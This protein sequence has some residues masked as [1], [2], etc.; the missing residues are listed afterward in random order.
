MRYRFRLTYAKNELM[1]YTSNL[2]VHKSWE[3]TIRRA[4]LPIA[5]SEGF[6][7]QPKIQL[8][9]PLPLGFLSENE[10]LDFELNENLPT[11]EILNLLK[12]KT[13]PGFEIFEIKEVLEKQPSLQVQT[14][15]SQYRIEFL[16]PQAFDLLQARCQNILNEI[17]IQRERRGKK[18]DLR[19]LIEMLNLSL[20]DQDPILTM[21]LSARAGATGRPEEVL[22]Q[23]NIPLNK[24]RITR[25]KT[26]LD[27]IL[28]N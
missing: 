15:A 1:R 5:Y 20:E 14:V 4:K 17:T 24:T 3:R 9:C 12:G 13:P 28:V 18:Y 2:D 16:E 23:L 22:D 6:H 8:A 10:I 7:P 21:K 27:P 25:E 19:P 11:N 26:I